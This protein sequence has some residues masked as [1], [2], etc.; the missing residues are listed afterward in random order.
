MNRPIR[1]VVLGAAGRD[2]HDVQT[3][4]KRHPDWRVVAIT[5]AQ[6]PFIER[7]SFPRELAGE[8]YDEDIPI[9]LESELPTLLRDLSVDLVALSY[10]DLSHAEVMHKASLALSHGAGFVLLPPRETTLQSQRPVVS[11]TAVRTGAGKSPLTQHI[12]RSLA[13]RVAVLR[14]PMPYGDI[15][16]QRAERFAV[17]ADLDRYECTLEEREEYLPY[18]EMGLTVFAGVDYQRILEAAE[19][20]CDVILWDGGNNDL[21]FVRP[22]LSIT[23]V[24][25][26]RPGHEVGY[27]PGEANLRAAD[28]VAIN[29]VSGATPEALAAVRANVAAYAPGARVI[30]SDLEVWAEPEEIIRGRRALV[31]ED[32][33]TVTHGGM[34]Y[35]AGTLAA[36]RYGA[37]ELIDPRPFA[38]GTVAAAYAAYPHMGAVLPALGYAEAQRAELAETIRRCAPEV[39]VDGSPARVARTLGVDVPVARVR[40]RFV[41]RAGDDVMDLVDAALARK[42]SR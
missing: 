32:G 38:V 23:V 11:V 21:P 41:Q 28:V 6:I 42:V 20:E 17:E 36:R 1:C 27:H 19:R 40:Y 24:D 16:R 12:A 25:A 4:F 31:I 14:H 35:G 30:E 8:G 2:F 33:P 34:A 26:L 22:D 29:K 37:R 39:V 7:R 3:F 5:A 15:L 18:L 9:R 10:S 13:S